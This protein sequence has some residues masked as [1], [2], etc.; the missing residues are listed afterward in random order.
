MRSSGRMTAPCRTEL[1]QPAKW[2]FRDRNDRED[3]M[4]SDDGPAE[5]THPHDPVASAEA[6]ASVQ[7]RRATPRPTDGTQLSPAQPRAQA[8]S[9]P[10]RHRRMCGRPG[11]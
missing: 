4:T 9:G 8:V 2:M 7:H 5:W 3:A 11:L 1:T 6:S 10:A